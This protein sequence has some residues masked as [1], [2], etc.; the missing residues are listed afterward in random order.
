[1][2]FELGFAGL[3][4]GFTGLGLHLR[5]GLKFI[6]LFLHLRDQLVS[7]HLGVRFDFT[8]LG[9]QRGQRGVHLVKTLFDKP[10]AFCGKCCDRKSRALPGIPAV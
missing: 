5:L 7:L 2:R 10:A 4:G 6:T 3:Q 1:M 9:L 8:R